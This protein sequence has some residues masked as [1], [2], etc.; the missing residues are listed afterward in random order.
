MKKM[1][2]NRGE[3]I[4]EVLAAILVATLAVTLLFSCDRLATENGA[5][6]EEIDVSHYNDL[7]AAESHETTLDTITVKITSEP[8]WGAPV[9]PAPTP[10]INIHGSSGGAS[11]YSYTRQS[12]T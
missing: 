9:N 10:A 4:I 7:T 11:M 1:S 8:S 2:N 5:K 3:T 12:E 6:A